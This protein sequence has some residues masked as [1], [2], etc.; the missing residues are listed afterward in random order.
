MRPRHAKFFSIAVPLLGILMAD[1]CQRNGGGTY[2]AKVGNSTLSKTDI[3]HMRTQSGDS[4][5]DSRRFI[6]EWVITELL[7]QEAER[8]GVADDDD[9]RRQAEQARRHFAVAALLQ[10]EIYDDTSG[11]NQDSLEA[12][13]LLNKTDYTLHEDAVNLSYA[14]FTDREAANTFR[15]KLLRHVPWDQALATFQNDSTGHGPLFQSADRQYFTRGR[16]YPP[17]IWKLALTIPRGEVS[18]VLKVDKSFYVLITNSIMRQGTIPELKYVQND[19]RDRLLIDHRR[20]RYE[21]L[22][23]SLRARANVDVVS[24]N[25]PND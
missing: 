22:I 11:V 8:R 24:G 13:Y 5:L 21:R 17:E 3:E 23:S 16:S 15:T 20:A 19:V 2:V 14:A 4:V 18:F 9:V 25:A 10:R 12:Y 6:D 7:Y 1:G